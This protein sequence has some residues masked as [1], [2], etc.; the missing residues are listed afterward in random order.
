MK[1]LIV[2]GKVISTERNNY[3]NRTPLEN[4]AHASEKESSAVSF[5]NDSQKRFS[6]AS[7]DVDARHWLASELTLLNLLQ[8]H[9]S[10][11]ICELA[12]CLPFKTCIQVYN[13]LAEVKLIRE[14]TSKHV[15]PEHENSIFEDSDMMSATDSASESRADPSGSDTSSTARG[16]K[17]SN[18]RKPVFKNTV[19]LKFD[20][21]SCFKIRFVN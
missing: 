16:L 8:P 10:Q 7:E 9:L 17:A 5:K 1:K 4:D 19:S 2:V 3:F 15:V 14:K 18:V 21:L 6:K 11:N 13:K 12:G 20:D